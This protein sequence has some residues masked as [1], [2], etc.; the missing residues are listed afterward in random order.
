MCRGANNSIDSRLHDAR[1]AIL[2]AGPTGLGAAYRLRELGFSQFVV[3]EREQHPG[4]LASSFTDEHGFTWD[5]GGHVQFSHYQ[6]F[7][8]LMEKL[9]GDEWVYHERE[10]WIWI[11]DR[12]VPYPFQNN[13]RYLPKPAMR[14]CLRGLIET[15]Q[16]GHNTCPKNFAEW[17]LANFGDGVAR[18][19]LLPYNFK[20]WAYPPSSMSYQWVGERVAKVDLERIIFNIIDNRQDGN[21]GPNNTFRFPLR[22]GTGEVWRRLAGRLPADSV[23]YGKKLS[24]LN[25]RQKK[26]QFSDGTTEH[27]D[28]LISTI[29]LDRLVALSDVS[30]ELKALGERLMYS[31]VNVV[32]IGLRGA[33]SARLNTKCWMY[34]PENSS[35]FYRATVFSNYSPHN[36]PDIAKNWSLMVEVSESRVKQVDHVHVLDSVVD[37]LLRTRL[38]DSRNDIVS[39]WHFVAEHGY[40]TPFLKRDE[41]IGSLLP[42]L[43]SQDIYSRGRFGAWKYEVSNQDHSLMQGVEL[44]DRLANGAPEFTINEPNLVNSVATR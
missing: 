2:G 1:I 24:R 3:F 5:V 26:L 27:Y 30:P 29:P 37:G 11:F 33:P 8:D 22:G 14:E 32:G 16:N 19:F 9:M 35:P 13:I 42:V 18:H 15:H 44:V 4:G 12:F 7:D 6:Y 39:A 25:T 40:P 20:V 36:V 23:H 21:W 34:F 31:T 43:E 38:I 10:S 17:I 41:V 28:I